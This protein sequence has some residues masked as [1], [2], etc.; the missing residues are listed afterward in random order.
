MRRLAVLVAVPLALAVAMPSLA[1]AA[2]A[3][4]V[5]YSPPVDAPVV[6][7][8][9]PPVERWHP[10]NRGVE[11]D[12]TSG[13][14]VA[15]AADG[16][17]TFAGQVGGELHVVVLHADGVR[18]TYAFLRTV[19]VRRGDTVHQGQP[20]GTAADTF[21][22]GAR[23]GDVYVDPLLLFGAG[24]PEV[25][26]VPDG[27]LGMAPEEDEKRGLFGQILHFGGAATTW[28]VEWAGGQVD[29]RLTELRGLV[30]YAFESNPLVPLVRVAG[31]GVEWFRAR[32]HCTPGD[33]AQPRLAERHVAVLVGGLW[34]SSANAA[35][36]DLDTAA[37]G[38]APG[39]VSR[40]SYQ[41]GSTAAA[42]YEPADTTVDIRHSA[43]LLR[44]YLQQVEVDNP[45]VPIDVIAHSQGGLVA[46][47]A[48]TNEFDGLDPSLPQ[49]SSLVTLGTPHQGTDLATAARMIGVTTSGKAG[50]AVVGW[51]SPWNVRSTS[52]QQLAETSSFIRELN[53]RPLPEGL[54]ATAIGARG[55][56]VAPA[57]H[58]GFDGAEN[59]VVSV[60]GVFTDHDRLPGSAQAQR[61]VAL[62]VNHLSPTCQS[63]TDAM[64]DEFV[65]GRLASLGDD[66]GRLG[67]LGGRWLDRR[68]G[69]YGTDLLLRKG[70][71]P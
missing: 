38:Y 49:V 11:Y 4:R 51:M 39:D 57:V 31:A 30:H 8:F 9:R 5:A 29:D 54:H 45:G 55:D 1:R 32:S 42:P 24:L 53:R 26:L 71:S 13:D 69:T 70:G 21:H 47:E 63:F 52:V 48:L 2:P 22:F 62:A 33:V 36:D 60:P 10:G 19:D 40:F 15:A 68:A 66:L 34:S 50:E 43:R 17:V 27:D 20:V 46:R 65:S 18:T 44:E 14:G 16:V 12:T 3:Q 25:H 41:G 58:T 59:V 37:L 64:V 35:I 61:E 28:A 7:T 6:D 23:I 67:W 56:L